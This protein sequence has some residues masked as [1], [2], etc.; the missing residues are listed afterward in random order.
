M[1]ALSSVA[2]LA[3]RPYSLNSL[4][5]LLAAPDQPVTR[6]FCKCPHIYSLI[7]RLPQIL[8]LE[9]AT[10]GQTSRFERAKTK[11]T[12]HNASPKL[13]TMLQS[14]VFGLSAWRLYLF[15]L[16]PKPQIRMSCNAIQSLQTP[17][18]H[19]QTSRPGAGGPLQQRKSSCR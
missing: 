19:A 18:F 1:F 4:V 6:R 17:R 5:G 9:S 8:N 16:T 13:L 3:R 10:L 15:E 12:V 14:R 7:H 11:G 2:P